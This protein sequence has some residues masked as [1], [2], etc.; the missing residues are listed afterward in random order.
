MLITIKKNKEVFKR[1][2]PTSWEQVPFNK[3][4]KLAECGNDYVKILSLFTGIPEDTI[5]TATV[6]HENSLFAIIQTLS[7]L[8]VEMTIEF[9]SVCMG[10]AMPKD[11]DFQSIG[12]FEDIKTLIE[13]TKPE[14]LINKYPLIVATYAKRFVNGEQ[15]PYDFKAAEL[16]AGHFEDAPC[17][18]V[19][20]IGN[21]TVARY[22]ALK[23]NMKVGSLNRVSVMKKYRLGLRGLAQST[24]SSLRSTI[25]KKNSHSTETK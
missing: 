12:Q 11:I 22:I 24:V 19:M 2:I 15:I 21:F 10:Y 20:G 23:G 5:R 14:E 25:S 13:E 4:L 7:F 6:E 3:F 8:K 17:T 1:E 16:L 9:P 18:E